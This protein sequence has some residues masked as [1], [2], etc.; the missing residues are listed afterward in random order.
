MFQHVPMRCVLRM[1]LFVLES[2]LPLQ[3][4]FGVCFEL[5]QPDHLCS[6]RGS[7][8]SCACLDKPVLHIDRMPTCGDTMLISRYSIVPIVAVVLILGV[9]RVAFLSEIYSVVFAGNWALACILLGST[10]ILWRLVG[11]AFTFCTLGMAVGAWLGGQAWGGLALILTGPLVL[12]Y[13]GLWSYR[14]LAKPDESTA[15]SRSRTFAA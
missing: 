2:D 9:N 7:A 4:L 12:G 13:M 14:S 10:G 1:H 3:L 8:L 15:A 11:G 5:R 6:L